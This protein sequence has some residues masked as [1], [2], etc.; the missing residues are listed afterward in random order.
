[1][2]KIIIVFICII[3]IFM[4]TGCGKN[5]TDIFKESNHPRTDSYNATFNTMCKSEGNLTVHIAENI[6]EEDKAEEIFQKIKKDY[7]KIIKD[8][9]QK[10][11]QVNVYLVS[12]TISGKVYNTENEI[13]CTIPDLEKED[14]QICLTKETLNLKDM[15]QCIGLSNIIFGNKNQNLNEDKLKEYYGNL[16]NINTLSM[17]PAYYID[18]F[19]DEDTVKIAT[20]TAYYLTKYIIDSEGIE[21]YLT[22][23]NEIGYRNQWLKSLGVKEE[24]PWNEEEIDI[25]SNI[26]FKM[27]EKYP[28]ILNV[29]NWNYNFQ[30]TDWLQNA[31]D[32]LAFWIKTLKGYS[33]LLGKFEEDN[34]LDTEQ[35]GKALE[36]EKQIY[37]LEI[38]DGINVTD[39]NVIELRTENNIW[40][41][42]VHVFISPSSI[43][44]KRW[45]AEGIAEYYGLQIQ[46]KYGQSINKKGVFNYL[47]YD[48]KETDTDS[49][50]IFEKKTIDYYLKFSDLPSNEDNINEELL[51]EAW[52]ITAVR[53]PELNS[54]VP[55]IETSIANTS[56]TQSKLENEGGNS[57]S[58][59]EA[60][61]FVKYLIENYGIDTVVSAISEYE[62]IEKYFEKDYEELYSDFLNY[63][64]E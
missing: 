15:W 58:Y 36:T 3:Q 46:N 2:K 45:L 40:H 13:Y 37:L 42:M 27:S 10:E 29:D 34:L 50:S 49:E 59:P 28:L 52:G 21:K 32:M 53:N 8:T 44:N 54:G 20:A 14:Y 38:E 47:T 60:Y 57:L 33:E 4:F 12:E 7:D 41:E 35:F 56:S 39:E 64:A 23:G 31:D 1:M 5:S 61:V 11:N 24:C 63:V 48:V 9:K 18:D 6:Y 17:F 55:V 25:L 22:N 26:D 62:N 43:E 30:V 16:K 19:T 51:Y